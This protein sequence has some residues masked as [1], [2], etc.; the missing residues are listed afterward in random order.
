MA[1]KDTNKILGMN[2]DQWV[3]R[4]GVGG[5]ERE[6][7]ISSLI[8]NIGTTQRQA[9]NRGDEIAAANDLPLAT[10]IAM[11]RGTDLGTQEAIGTGIEGIERYA[12]QANREAWGQIMRADMGET[13]MEKGAEAQDEA[14]WADLLMTAGKAAPF[15]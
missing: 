11:K 1:A 12:N 7:M 4:L 3:N 8:R 5:K 13:S 15:L 9:Y 6:D 10:Q 2:Y 14:F